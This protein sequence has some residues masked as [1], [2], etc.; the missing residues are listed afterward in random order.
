MIERLKIMGNKA[1]QYRPSH[2][3]LLDTLSRNECARPDCDKALVARDGVSIVS[4]ICHIKAASP[5]GSRYDASMTDDERRH[6]DN[7]I[8]LCDECHIIID[9][10]A[11]E[12]R[13]TVELL[14]EWKSNHEQ[15]TKLRLQSKRSYLS[16]AIEALS[17]MEFDPDHQA[18]APPR[19]AINIDDKIRQNKVVRNLPL[20]QEHKIYYSKIAAL[21]EELEAQG[22]FKKDNLLRNIRR[23]YLQVKGQYI[24][25]ANSPGQ[26]SDHADDIF[27]D[28][29]ERLLA[30][31]EKSAGLWDED[32][33]FGISIIMVDAF[34][35]CKILEEPVTV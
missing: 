17:A 5:E 25:D 1:R 28:V 2:V 4:K 15:E 13:Y 34:M 3:R 14:R 27:E 29:E 22:S 7:L 21:Y 20:I 35:R 33:S 24:S 30:A 23:I 12:H 19:N 31:C 9:N 18:I 26:V 8:L 10:K 16:S 11:N 32:I 6:G